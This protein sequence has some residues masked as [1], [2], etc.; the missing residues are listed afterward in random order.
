MAVDIVDKDRRARH[1]ELIDKNT[2]S[3]VRTLEA[4]GHL[5][6][7]EYTRDGKYLY[8]SGG[9]TGDRLHIYDSHSLEEVASYPLETPAGIFSRARTEWGTVGLPLALEGSVKP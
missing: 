7:P 8:V 5:Y 2:L 6:F 9:Y 3:V 1:V 4:D